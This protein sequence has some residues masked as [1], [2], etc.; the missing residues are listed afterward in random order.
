MLIEKYINS[1]ILLP[2]QVS[3]VSKE[4]VYVLEAATDLPITA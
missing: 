4:V 2:V 1:R 3:R